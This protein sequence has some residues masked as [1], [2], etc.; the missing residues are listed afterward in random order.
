MSGAA[1][2]FVQVGVRRVLRAV[3]LLTMF[4]MLTACGL[5]RHKDAP[6]IAPPSGAIEPTCVP[7][8]A[9]NLLIGTWYLVSKQAGVAGEMQ[10]LLT[11]SADGKLKQQTRIKQGR[12]IRS[13]L[14]ETGCWEAPAGKLITRV[15]RSNG[16]LI[17][18]K[19]PIYSTTYVVEKVDANRL[20]YRLDRPDS[21][22]AFAKKV[23]DSFRLL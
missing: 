5:P 7:L 23:Q 14:R 1:V 12:N 2:F 20:T 13:E 4:S 21:K 16:E 8:N 11:L 15:S 18:F 10:T 19:D 22:P 9:G 17:D 6:V 3:L